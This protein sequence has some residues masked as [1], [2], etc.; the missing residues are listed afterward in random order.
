MTPGHWQ[1]SFENVGQSLHLIFSFDF[2][3]DG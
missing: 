1:K 3:A 2:G